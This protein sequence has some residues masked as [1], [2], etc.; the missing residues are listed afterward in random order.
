M[1]VVYRQV[2]QRG[3]RRAKVPGTSAWDLSEVS[4]T[5]SRRLGS[6]RYAATG[7]AGKIVAVNLELPGKKL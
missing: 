5:T 3:C 1:D 6:R 2:R 4:T 7:G